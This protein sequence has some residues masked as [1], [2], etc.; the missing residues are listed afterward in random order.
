MQPDGGIA[1][2]RAWGV[3]D[4]DF[5]VELSPAAVGRVDLLSET[6]GARAV[7]ASDAHYGDPRNLLRAGRGAR[8]DDG[9][10]PPSTLH[11]HS[12]PLDDGCRPLHPHSIHTPYRHARLLHGAAC[13]RHAAQ[14]QATPSRA[15]P[16]PRLR[17]ARAQPT[18]A[19]PPPHRDG[20]QVGDGSTARP[21][22]FDRHRR[23][24][25]LRGRLA[26]RRRTL[27]GVLRLVARGAGGGAEPARAST[28]PL[29]RTPR[30]LHESTTPP[31]GNRLGHS[32]ASASRSCGR[33]RQRRQC[34]QL[35]RSPRPR[36]PRTPKS[37]AAPLA[38]S[39][40]PLAPSTAPLA[41][42]AAPL[43]P[44]GGSRRPLPRSTRL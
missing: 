1:R 40:A 36:S 28:R 44:S 22:A 6:L 23:R 3:V 19:Q 33:S 2:L 13:A 14:E 43:A 16:A 27:F 9:C 35:Q 12:T 30:A 38:P 8:M 10:R 7:G 20:R 5:D 41:P 39:A 31:A 11:P 17:P 34:P 32:A 37:S 42:S 18:L 15:K 4:R 29:V 24:H 26:L 21:P 25:R